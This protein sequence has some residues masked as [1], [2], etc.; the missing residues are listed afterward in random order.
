MI[1]PDEKLG[2]R[3]AKQQGSFWLHATMNGDVRVDVLDNNDEPI[4]FF[5]IPQSDVTKIA[6]Q[7]VTLAG[8]VQ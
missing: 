8:S 1:H 7:M 5:I 6:M 3:P 2:Y 4:C